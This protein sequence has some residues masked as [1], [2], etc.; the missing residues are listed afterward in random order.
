MLCYL[1]AG[2][3]PIDEADRLLVLDVGDGHVDVLGR[4][5]AAVEEAAR[6]VLALAEVAAHELV[7]RVEAGGGDVADTHVLVEGLGAGE[8][9]C[10]GGEREVDARVR[11]QVRLELVHVHVERAV[12]PQRRR[13]RRDHLR[14]ETTEYIIIVCHAGR[15]Q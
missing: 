4:D 14:E 8:Q 9:R 12:E 15:G 7:G 1:E 3:A 10:E 5:V 2:G 6:H 11:H 13:H